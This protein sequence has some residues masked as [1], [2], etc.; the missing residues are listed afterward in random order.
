MVGG[1]ALILLSQAA[2]NTSHQ[3][4]TN[5]SIENQRSSVNGTSSNLSSSNNSAPLNQDN[6]RQGQTNKTTAQRN[7]GVKIQEQIDKIAD[8]IF[9]D[10]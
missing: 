6:D 4:L 9:Y 8:K 3:N 1:T 10:R 5:S 2:W 7:Q